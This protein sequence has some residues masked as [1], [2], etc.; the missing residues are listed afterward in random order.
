MG[1]DSALAGRPNQSE[2]MNVLEPTERLEIGG[3]EV[4][5][6]EL[7]WPQATRFLEDLSADITQLL[8]KGQFTVSQENVELLLRGSTKTMGRLVLLSTGKDLAWLEARRMSE[9]AQVFEVALRLTLNDTLLSA[10]KNAAERLGA[11]FGKN[12]L[13]PRSLAK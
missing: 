1:G 7:T 11:A 3:E 13:T 12:G 4:T 2:Y 9:V 5:V 8:S 10:G 6:R